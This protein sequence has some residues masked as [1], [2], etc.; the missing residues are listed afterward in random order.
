MQMAR[1]PGPGNAPQIEADVESVGCEYPAVETGHGPQLVLAREELGI[2]EFVEIP[3][4]CQWGDEQM[5]VVVRKPIEHDERRFAAQD[6]EI[7][8]VVAR[9]LSIAAQ[10]TA[11]TGGLVPRIHDV[12]K[13]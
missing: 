12:G 3:F 13:P 8:I 7:L 4:M 9:V 2:I 5:A 10:E 11:I 1:K 6:H